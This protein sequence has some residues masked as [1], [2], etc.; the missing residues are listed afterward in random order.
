MYESVEVVKQ[1]NSMSQQ[2]TADTE[3]GLTNRLQAG[4]MV[5]ALRKLD[6]LYKA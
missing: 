3:N 6:A 5:A 2:A 1:V 4:Q